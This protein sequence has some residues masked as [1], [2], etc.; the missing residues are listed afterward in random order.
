MFTVRAVPRHYPEYCWDRRQ[1]HRNPQPTTC[2]HAFNQR[3]LSRHPRDSGV[4]EFTERILLPLL[5]AMTGHVAERQCEKLAPPTSKKWVHRLNLKGY[6]PDD[7]TIT[8]RDGRILI[9]ARRTEG[10]GDN[11]DVYE[12][13]RNITI[14]DEVD[15]DSMKSHFTPDG[16]L[17]IEAKFVTK[18]E[19]NTK[20]LVVTLQKPKDEQTQDNV[21]EHQQEHIEGHDDEGSEE[22]DT[23]VTI[24]Y[25]DDF[26]HVEPQSPSFNKDVDA[27]E[28]NVVVGHEQ[29]PFHEELTS[30]NGE[31]AENS[32]EN[33]EETSVTRD[34][35]EKRVTDDNV[36]NFKLSFNK[37]QFPGDDV[38]VLVKGNSLLVK[39]EK[40]ESD[41]GLIRTEYYA[42][43]YTLPDNV[44]I[45]NI[46]CSKN[47][48]G[49]LCVSVPYKESQM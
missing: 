46:S 17:T 35:D 29:F 28:T 19:D 2:R 13:H 21:S 48:E 32:E 30:P 36:K 1:S 34:V 3:P 16:M 11:S 24:E 45:G 9:K 38:K 26:E 23:E 43:Q 12:S 49:E 10:E 20:E 8:T 22:K 40:N 33:V 15:I 7:V 14:P 31:Y 4:H 39:S 42:R 47:S 25:P 37:E 5:S 44:D 18:D 27:Q 41:D 6:G